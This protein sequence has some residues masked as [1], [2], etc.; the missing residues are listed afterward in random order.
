MHGVPRTPTWTSL[1]TTVFPN[2]NQI[3]VMEDVDWKAGEYIVIAP[4]GFTIDETEKVQ[5]L[6][7]E[8]DKRTINLVNPLQYKH[9]A[10]VESHGTD[11]IEMRAE[12]GLLTRN[13]VYRGDETSAANQ[14]G[15]HIMMHY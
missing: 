13:V 12:V 6:S 2:S 7:V 14:F 1:E 11:T 10:A 9:Y 3:K 5:I 4:T 8:A 15:A